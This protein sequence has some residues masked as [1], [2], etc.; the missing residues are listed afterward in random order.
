MSQNVGMQV[1]YCVFIPKMRRKVLLGRLKHG[2]G[3]IFHALANRIGCRIIEEH[4]CIDHVHMCSE[5]PPKISVSQA[6]GYIKGK[7]AI[8]IARDFMGWAR[9]FSGE[10]FWACCYYVSTVGVIGRL[11]VNILR[12]K[13]VKM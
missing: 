9:N 1:P 8:T 4:V 13:S 2:L 11:F 3:P 12:T 6:I 10:N 5:I 7:S